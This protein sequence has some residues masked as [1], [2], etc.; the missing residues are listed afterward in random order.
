MK[1]ASGKILARD[2]GF[3]WKAMPPT[4]KN[5]LEVGKKRS[6]VD[7]VLCIKLKM[8]LTFW[9]CRQPGEIKQLAMILEL[10]FSRQGLKQRP[11]GISGIANTSG[12]QR[13]K[14]AGLQCVLRHWLSGR[15][16]LGGMWRRSPT[17]W[18]RKGNCKG[19]YGTTASCGCLYMA[20]PHRERKELTLNKRLRNVFIFAPSLRLTA[21]G[22]RCELLFYKIIVWM[23]VSAS[24][25]RFASVWVILQGGA[26]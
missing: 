1:E 2:N 3:V 4:K 25:L 5:C 7:S 11:H 13:N 20:A 9:K 26:A 10:F 15:T 21:W 8:P 23:N 16:G 22:T 6:S 12:L 14:R 17:W 19:C 24:V 18:K